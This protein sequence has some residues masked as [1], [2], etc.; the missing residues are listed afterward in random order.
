MALL[1]LK[2]KPNNVEIDRKEVIRVI[3]ENLDKKLSD[4]QLKKFELLLTQ[5]PLKFQAVLYEL[6]KHIDL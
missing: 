1:N 5:H 6:D 3:S 4:I 2:K